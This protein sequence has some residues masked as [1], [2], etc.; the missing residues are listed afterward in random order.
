M[1]RKS[2]SGPATDPELLI[3]SSLSAGPKHGYAIMQDVA[4]FAGITLGPGTLYTAIT[5]L[6]DEEY[7]EPLEA[8][9]K[10]RPYRITRTGLDHLRA[11][12]EA[13]RRLA[14]HGLRRLRTV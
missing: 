1:A 4:I 10:Q 14:T 2:A 12:L 3:L 8:I 5:R 13:M 11:Q 7:I 6:M 9:G